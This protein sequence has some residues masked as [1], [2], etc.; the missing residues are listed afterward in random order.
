M[1]N[2]EQFGGNALK[3]H[4]VND[5]ESTVL[6]I[7]AVREIDVKDNEQASGYRRSLLLT[8]K[9]FPNND[10]WCNRTDA[11]ILIDEFGEDEKRWV[12]KEVPL[13]REENEN[14]RKRGEV[15]ANLHVAKR[16]EWKDVFAAFARAKRGGRASK[17]V[18]KTAPKRGRKS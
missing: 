9:E 17:T 1:L 5:A 18:R 15:V 16:G 4:H 2:R 7:G 10:F 14:P 12:G 13:V 8:F 11:L 6:T 3:P